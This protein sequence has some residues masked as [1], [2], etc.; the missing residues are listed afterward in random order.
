MYYLHLTY[1]IPLLCRCNLSLV[2]KCIDVA[3]IDVEISLL[4]VKPPLPPSFLPPFLVDIRL[5]LIEH[6][7]LSLPTLVPPFFP[8][9]KARDPISQKPK[10]GKR[11]LVRQR[12]LVLSFT[13]AP[14]TEKSVHQLWVLNPIYSTGLQLQHHNHTCIIIQI[15]M[16]TLTPLGPAKI[17]SL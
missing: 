13:F 15:S 10:E 5:R 3:C 9:S 6:G 16:R 14:A 1:S 4:F 12:N 11:N 17:F 7:S 8:I 2:P